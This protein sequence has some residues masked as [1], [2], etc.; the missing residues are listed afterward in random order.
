LTRDKCKNSLIFFI[1]APKKERES[2]FHQ[3]RL[4]MGY[5]DDMGKPNLFSIPKRYPEFRKLWLAQLANN[6]GNQ[7]TFLAL[8]FLVFS[9]TGSPLAMGILAMGEAVPMI[10]VGPYAG[11][12][13]DRYDRQKVMISANVIQS[14]LLIGIALTGF[15]DPSIRVIF[16]FAL[17]FGNGIMNRFFLPSRSA[18]IPKLVT[19]EDLLSANS[20]SAAT[21]QIAALL[22]PMTAGLLVS[23]Y[24]YD[25][26]FLID[27]AGFLLSAAFIWRIKTDLRPENNQMADNM[28]RK[29]QRSV[30]A[31]LVQSLDYIKEYHALGY[32]MVLFGCLLFSFGAVMILLIP[33]L[34]EIPNPFPITPE[35]TYGIISGLAAFV[36]FIVAIIVG[37][38]RE[39]SR[40]LLLMTLA[41]VI[42][43]FIMYGFSIAQDV[44]GL[45][46][47]WLFFGMIQVFVMIPF[48]TLTQETIPDVLRGKLFSFFNIVFSVSRIIGMGVGGILAEFTTVRITFFWGAT[49]MVITGVACLGILLWKKL[50]VQ[51]RE[52]RE[53][54]TSNFSSVK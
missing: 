15:I 6:I 32:I 17:A 33:F 34:T 52:R 49:A 44:I 35:E 39:L 20:L 14:S 4:L 29:T 8:Q 16:I 46:L 53:L 31:D 41:A 25:L 1:D 42:G 19:R 13:I 2:F 38:K 23:F 9:L 22:G 7:F 5:N 37:R 18:S 10:L 47:F 43:S 30:K 12:L 24:G 3:G 11:I 51:V 36:G 27:A 45:A 40:P 48:Q 21:F 28:V 50:D 26:A 54:L